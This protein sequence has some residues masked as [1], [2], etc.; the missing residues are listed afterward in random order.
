MDQT[1]QH[2]RQIEEPAVV[3]CGAR[4]V[5]IDADCRG[6][7]LDQVAIDRIN[8]RLAAIRRSGL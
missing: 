4:K 1:S 6:P 8:E 2:Q 3:E 7:A 5:V